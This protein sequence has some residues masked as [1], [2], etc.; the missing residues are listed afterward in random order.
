MGVDYAH[1]AHVCDELER[2]KAELENKKQCNYCNILRAEINELNLKIEV[3][4]SDIK[5]I[6]D[7][8][9]ENSKEAIEK[10]GKKKGKK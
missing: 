8:Y 3:L 10:I 6:R 9:F 1:Y 5:K 4:E 2:L 7:N